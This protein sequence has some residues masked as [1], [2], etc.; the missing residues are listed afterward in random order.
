MLHIDVAPN[1]H[2]YAKLEERSLIEMSTPGFTA[3]ASLYKTSGRYQAVAT[4]G[5]GNG[6]QSVISQLRI[7]PFGGARGAGSFSLFGGWFCRLLCEIAYS[8]CLDTCEGTLDNP[9]P[10]LNCVICDQEHNA[11][12][13]GCG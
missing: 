5:Y 6:D 12:L 11:C 3:E 2:Y 7:D 4:Q 13:Q 8:S 9:K 1:I 10:S